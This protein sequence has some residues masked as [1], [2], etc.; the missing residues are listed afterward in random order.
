[1]TKR[2][3]D[4]ERMKRRYLEHLK[5]AIG[6]DEASLDAVAKAI[7]RFETHSKYRDFRKFHIEQARA[8]KAALMETTNVRTGKR[9]SASTIN[10]TPAAV[11]AFFEWLAQWP[12][13]RSRIKPADAAY[14]NPPDNL[15]RIATAYRFK[16]C[17][18]LKQVRVA[19]FAM[20]AST[21]V[22]RR[23]QAIVA[24]TIL[25]GARDRAIISLKLKHIDVENERLDQDARQ[26]RTKR[27]K[28]MTTWFFPVGKDIRAIVVDW[29]KFLRTAKGFGPEDPIFPKTRVENGPDLKLR[30]AGL[31][32]EHWSNASPVRKIFR[33]AFQRVGLP[34]FNPHSARNTLVQLAYDLKLDPATFRAWSQN[35]GHESCLTTFSSYGTLSPARQGE[36]IRG[37]D[38]RSESACSTVV[39]DIAPTAL[40]TAEKL[41]QLANQIE[42]ADQER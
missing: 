37:L 38:A 8:F 23:D 5:D 1:M 33:E 18:T 21:E 32:R 12:P 15:A 3:P 9:L 30:S 2:H 34:A 29:V 13:Y 40:S 41:R 20:P 11:K 42:R 22:E 27:A 16:P 7:E 31:G 24:L 36:L 6:R 19:L 35:L 26:V 14:F 17:A 28:T 10:S 4:N 39:P 25:T